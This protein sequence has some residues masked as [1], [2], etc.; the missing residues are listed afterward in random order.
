M[1]GGLEPFEDRVQ[2]GFT[3]TYFVDESTPYVGILRVRAA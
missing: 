3:V 2:S 1:V